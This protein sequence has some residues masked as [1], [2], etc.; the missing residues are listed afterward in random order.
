MELKSME[1]HCIT[2]ELCLTLIKMYIV[3]ELVAKQLSFLEVQALKDISWASQGFVL[4]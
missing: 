4:G 3:L 1:Q 2:Q